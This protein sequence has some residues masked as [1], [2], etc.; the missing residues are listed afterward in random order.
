[1]TRNLFRIAMAAAFVPAIAGAQ[2]GSLSFTGDYLG[3]TGGGLGAQITLLTVQSFQDVTGEGCTGE[4]WNA[5]N[6]A[7]ACQ[8]EAAAS[9]TFLDDVAQNGQ[10]QAQPLSLAALAGLNGSN[11]RIGVNTNDGDND[12]IV[13]DLRVILY[14]ASGQ[15][16]YSTFLTGTP[17]YPAGGTPGLLAA[18]G[19]GI[20]NFG[21]VFAF[22]D[23]AGAAAFT[24]AL[25]GASYIGAAGK[26][27][28]LQSMVT[29]NVAT[30][31][32][33]MAIPE[34]ATVLLMGTGLLG[35][36]VMARRRR[37]A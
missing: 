21:F 22:S 8:L 26:F 10:T 32:N 29:V 9:G 28:D 30:F 1:M 15:V 12:F 6:S 27:G 13:Q 20:G 25:A 36:G 24:A 17:T 37:K 18:A 23:A 5:A 2:T 3:A 11:L 35:I 4:T 33:S 7:Q 19:S 31:D 14:N 34:P 16:Y